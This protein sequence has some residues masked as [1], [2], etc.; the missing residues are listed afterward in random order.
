M[1]S[2]FAFLAAAAVALALWAGHAGAATMEPDVPFVPTPPAV[3]DTML[4]LA[5]V[6]ARDYVID[7]GS[8]DGR[9]LIAAAKRHGARGY[10]VEIEGSLVSAARAEAERQGVGARVEFRE[11]N[12]HITDFSRAS[13]MTLY[14]Y[15]KLLMD[16]R[17]RFLADLKP[18]SRIV[19]HDFDMD[20][21]RPDAHATV[22]VPGKPYG[23]PRSEV[24]LWI[25][26]ANAAGAWRWPSEAGEVNLQIAQA[27]QMLEGKGRV[28]AEEARL[29]QGR[30]RGA[31]IRFILT[32]LAQGRPVRQEYSGLVGGDTITGKVKTGGREAD[33][34]ATRSRRGS[35]S[36]KGVNGDR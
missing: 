23:P 27:F 20:D 22:P 29:E 12:L 24:F 3:V 34:T 33:W 1:R 6:G 15:P 13:V 26:P 30:M 31:E 8:G 4:K 35:I 11:E 18:G 21:W 9:I 19:S 10:G 16:L 28:G 14:L 2:A 32:S 5:E 17:P 7:L 36:L 25:V